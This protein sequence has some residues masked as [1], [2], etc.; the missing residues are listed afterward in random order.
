[1][2]TRTSSDDDPISSN[3]LLEA[4]RN[5]SK[6]VAL[7][8][9]SSRQ[10]LFPGE[11]KA[12]ARSG[13]DPEEALGYLSNWLN[14]HQASLTAEDP[15]STLEDRQGSAPAGS[16]PP[17]ESRARRDLA[18]LRRSLKVTSGEIAVLA[19]KDPSAVTHW[20][21]GQKKFPEP[22][23][24]GRSPLFNFD[25]VH[26]WLER[27]DKLVNEPDAAWLWRK[28][29]Q[30]LHQATGQEGRSRLRGYVTAMVVVLPDFLD[31]ISGFVEL[32]ETAGFEHWREETDWVLDDDQAKFLREHLIGVDTDHEARACT[33]R[34][35]RY[36]IDSECTQRGLLDDALDALDA[37]SP[38]Q[39]TTSLRVSAL[40]TRLA[41][42]L[43]NPPESVLDL[44]CGEATILADLLN[45]PPNLKP[46][47]SFKLRGIEKDPGTAAI[48]RI[49]LQ[50]HDSHGEVDW[51]IRV[52]DS[53]AAATP[54]EAFDVVV[55]DPPTKK[56]KEWVNLAKKS[57]AAN[58]TSRAFVLLPRS[59]LDA[60]G[61]C[62]SLIRERQLEAAVFL[63][64][65]LKK[66]SRGLALCVITSGSVPCEEILVIDL[67]DLKLKNLNFG[68][69]TPLADPPGYVLPIDEVCDAISHWRDTRT[70]NRDLLRG[71][72]ESITAD[73]AISHRHGTARR[74]LLSGADLYRTEPLGNGGF[75]VTATREVPEGA[76]L[77]ISV[78][79]DTDGGNPI[80][81]WQPA[82]FRLDYMT[83][84]IEGGQLVEKS[85]NKIQARS[86]G[87]EGLK[88]KVQGFD[89]NRDLFV[90]ASLSEDN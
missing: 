89:P 6:A 70:I 26:D 1:M 12:F 69:V 57:L 2:A 78:A 46:R 54:T 32:R 16:T 28:S 3:E 11:A 84:E 73:N 56:A 19:G 37:L 82:D 80:K 62:A 72:Q 39:T 31:D 45:P 5:Y 60:D 79:Y 81:N 13:I 75:S 40:I 4:A 42:D 20:R 63:P 59:A 74:S 34:A 55:V 35:F 41:Y 25:E 66:N 22:V 15:T 52:D 87:N 53:L 14:A 64:N 77:T 18:L 44:A 29:V 90:A 83:V 50:L 85:G 38:A 76:V 33:A 51:G 86:T 21:K 71:R 8:R 49:R 23:V 36:A 65:R 61:P 17:H 88:V 24:G 10:T 27:H 67:A 48:A 43:P 7:A 9:E 47:H 30:A 58:R 68:T